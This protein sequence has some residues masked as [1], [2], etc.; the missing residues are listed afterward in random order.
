M[1]APRVPF[2]AKDRQAARQVDDDVPAGVRTELLHIVVAYIDDERL[3]S[4]ST[5]ARAFQ[6]NGGI[7]PDLPGTAPARSDAHAAVVY[8]IVYDMQWQRV[9][10]TIEDL[11]EL[12]QPNQ[13]P[14]GYSDAPSRGNL[15]E[16]RRDFCMAVDRAFIV[17]NVAFEFSAGRVNRRGHSTTRSQ[18]NAA[19]QVLGD[20]RLRPARDHFNKALKYFHDPRNP[21]YENSV[22]EAVSAVESVAKALWPDLGSDYDKLLKRLSGVTPETLPAPILDTLAKLY[23]F[24][25][26]GTGVSH[27]GSKGGAVTPE[28]TEYVLATSASQI[29]LLYRFFQT[30]EPEIPF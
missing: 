6:R 20:V 26:S 7:L 10:D 28:I 16:V 18:T 17:G 24:R 9:M 30:T 3:P 5:V 22:K 15:E 21:D 23:A 25:G 2:S 4:W 27:G 29:V 14:E 12:L 1:T 19:G 13:F 8:K 11:F